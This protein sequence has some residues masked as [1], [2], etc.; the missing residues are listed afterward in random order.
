MLNAHIGDNL[1][2]KKKKKKGNFL[3]IDYHFGFIFLCDFKIIWW[4]NIKC[5][6]A[7]LKMF[8]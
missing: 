7:F 1:K 2:R 4:K 5:L 3:A 6:E 8:K